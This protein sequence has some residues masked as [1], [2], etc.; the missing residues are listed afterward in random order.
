[1]LPYWFI[2]FFFSLPWLLTLPPL[3]CQYSCSALQCRAGGKWVPACGCC[4][5]RGAFAELPP[6][7]FSTSKTKPTFLEQS[8]SPDTADCE[9]DPSSCS[10]QRA[11]VPA[12]KKQGC[13]C[14]KIPRWSVVNAANSPLQW[15]GTITKCQLPR[16][17]ISILNPAKRMWLYPVLGQGCSPTLVCTASSKRQL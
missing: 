1:M 8:N 16:Y 5:C 4:R 9:L 7:G 11:E 13:I 14:Y 15:L 2:F 12:V 17:L 3:L 10:Q 6:S